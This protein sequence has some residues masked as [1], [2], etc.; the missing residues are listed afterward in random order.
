MS[1]LDLIPMFNEVEPEELLALEML[2]NSRTYLKGSP[3]MKYGESGEEMMFIASGAVKVSL[4]NE[5]GKEFLIAR[6]GIG[7]MLGELAMITGD[8]RTAD[9]VAL[10]DTIVFVLNKKD[11]F[12][13]AKKY[14]G[15]SLALLRALARRLSYSTQ[16]SG[17]LALL[18]VYHRLIKVLSDM[19]EET[20]SNYRIINSRPTHQELAAMVGT[21][22]EVVS[23]ALK[24]MELEG[25]IEISGK[26]IK[27]IDNI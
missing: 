15:A 3:L 12:S 16:K 25:T 1:K 2:F 23:R 27:L 7:E 22:R 14:S 8:Q 21:S 26:Q 13:H 6:L 5:E 19:S 9:V 11:F 20:D 10:E 18:D 24:N 4:I 17:E